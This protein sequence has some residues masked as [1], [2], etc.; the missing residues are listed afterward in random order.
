MKTVA[1][2][3]RAHLDEIGADGLM[4][5]GK[6]ESF[7]AKETLADFIALNV[8]AVPAFRHADGSYHAEKE[9]GRNAP[10]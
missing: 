3:I 5:N 8:R 10:A 7:S 2:I 9:D 1:E 4:L 6:S